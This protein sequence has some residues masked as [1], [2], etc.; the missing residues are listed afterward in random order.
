VEP[1]AAPRRT[2][3]KFDQ[4]THEGRVAYTLARLS[5]EIE[6]PEP[7]EPVKVSKGEL[8]GLSWALANTA[9]VQSPA[10]LSP[11]HKAAYEVQER[12]RKAWVEAQERMADRMFADLTCSE[13]ASAPDV[14]A[15]KMREARRMQRDL[16]YARMRRKRRV[17]QFGQFAPGGPVLVRSY[18]RHGLEPQM[19]EI[20]DVHVAVGD[21]IGSRARP[22][23][24]HAARSSKAG[25]G[26]PD[27]ESPEGEADAAHLRGFLTHLIGFAWPEALIDSAYAFS[28]D[29]E[30]EVT[31]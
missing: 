24:R 6:A 16:T 26:S 4:D 7:R 3:R 11:E 9:P 27:G 14:K 15:I 1:K 5:G 13:A 22:R 30:G 23:E 31:S 10:D 2:P 20:A 17:F 12:K 8:E 28:L 25:R 18:D 19:S 21:P 29:I